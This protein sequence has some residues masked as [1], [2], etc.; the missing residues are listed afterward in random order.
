MMRLMFRNYFFPIGYEQT[1]DELKA[2]YIE[3][4]KFVVI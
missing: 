3:K 1:A 2:L 4:Q